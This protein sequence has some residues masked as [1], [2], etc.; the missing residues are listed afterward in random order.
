MSTKKAVIF[1]M[2]FHFTLMVAPKFY[3]VTAQVITGR[4]VGVVRD[5]SGG[6]IPG[7][8]IMLTNSATGVQ[9]KAESNEQGQ[10]VFANLPAGEYSITVTKAGFAKKIV[11][12]VELQVMQT[13]SVDLKLDVG[14][15]QG[16]VTVSGEPTLLQSQTS[17][18]GGVISPVEIKNIPLNGRNYL[19]LATLVPGV[20][21]FYS[22]MGTPYRDSNAWLGSNFMGG[23]QTVG[24]DLTV[25]INREVTTTYRLDR[26][27]IT[28]TWA[29][30]TALLPSVSGVQEFKVITGVAPASLGSPASVNVMTKGGTN[31]FH[32]TLYEYLR[33]DIFDAR[34]FFNRTGK[35]PAL[36]MNQFG[37]AVGGPIRKDRTFFF[38]NYEGFRSSRP[39]L[40][41][42]HVP[43]LAERSGDF[44]APGEPII[45]D[46]QTGQPFP[47]NII[48]SN[49]ISQFAKV[50]NQLIPEPNFTGTGPLAF[51]NF[52]G[53]LKPYFASDQ[54]SGRIDQ[55]IS[56]SDSLFGR[57][58]YYTTDNT[59]PGIRPEF[60]T[61][62]PYSGQSLVLTENHTFSPKLLNV[63]TAGY[64]R[65]ILAFAPTAAASGRNWVADMG[66][67]NIRGATDQTYYGVPLIY[68]DQVGVLGSGAGPRGSTS[69]VFEFQDDMTWVRGR[70]TLQWG[71]DLQHIQYNAD[72]ASVPRG[73]FYFLNI[74][75]THG[76]GTGKA[77]ADYLLGLPFLAIGEGG[78]SR[79]AMRWTTWEPY[80]QDDW[81]VTDRLTL[82]LGLRYAYK[83][84]P[85]DKYNHE[86]YF[87]TTTGTFVTSASG[88]I[89]NGIFFPPK[90]N[91]APRF[92]FAW[93]P[94]DK[95]VVRGGYGIYYTVVPQVESFFMA[96]FPP[97]T[98]AYSIVNSPAQPISSVF[99]ATP[100][101]TPGISNITF[102][103]EPHAP[104]PYY[105]QWDLSVQRE[106]TP[107]MSVQATYVGS[108]GTHLPRRTDINQAILGTTPLQSRRPWPQYGD[109][110]AQLNNAYSNYNALQIE[111]R[112]RTSHGLFLSAHYEH[113]NGFDNGSL[114]SNNPQNR[115]NAN[116]G[117][118]G[119]S[120]FLVRNRF[121]FSAVY[122][123]PFGQ[124]KWLL[125]RS[126]IVNKIVGG[127]GIA[128]ITLYQSGTPLTVTA[129]NYTPTGAYTAYYANRV[130]NGNL[131]KDQRTL[132]RFFDTSCFTQPAANTFGN[133]GRGVLTG[134]GLNNTDISIFKQT[135]IAEG[136]TIRFEAQFF[137]AFN[138]PQFL[139]PGTAVGSPTFGV[140]TGALQGRSIQFGLQFNF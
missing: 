96:G 47:G 93:T 80:I 134:P 76:A 1:V 70:H 99:P 110:L 122:E 26:V 52:T 5:T 73:L 16:A 81:R 121:L 32:G 39:G 95:T 35:K 129:T 72:N 50:Y 31:M 43:T 59:D 79:L 6:A 131:P 124:G 97:I 29:G 53:T 62:Y 100:P 71:I 30:N 78:T 42:L 82:N 7:A 66:I 33:N 38:A 67:N 105:Q 25:G 55:N 65:S 23:T 10:Y 106:L 104:T 140:I 51:A 44:S 48:P 58:T 118:Y 37:A 15:I 14:E 89:H 138:H 21:T 109:I 130:C 133:S 74:N 98:Q 139:A 86:G 36:R 119:P 49:R 69:N 132:S 136:K 27:N 125:N 115:L 126:G 137:N 3:P 113:A 77:V 103:A 20:N 61:R 18:V 9:S 107:T 114:V 60:G 116:R 102:T 117:E 83:T 2:L 112:K 64:T 120:D 13:A 123:L 135:S 24:T 87:D 88:G 45:Y 90:A 40:T 17:E 12:H 84:A 63:F 94:I 75:S 91:F 34:N 19:Q 128:D 54:Y 4:I 11:Q 68:I 56:S 57:Y 85:A 108:K 101:A 8:E 92:G 46:P 28:N 127:W 22:S 111:F 41:Y